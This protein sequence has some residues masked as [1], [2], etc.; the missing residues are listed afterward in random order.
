MI[1]LATAGSLALLMASLA[2]VGASAQGTAPSTELP[3]SQ[4]QVPTRDEPGGD[5]I[6]ANGRCGGV[7]TGT[8]ARRCGDATGGPADGIGSKN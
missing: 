5:G 8:G 7:S 2:P 1:K 4:G 3:R 6:A